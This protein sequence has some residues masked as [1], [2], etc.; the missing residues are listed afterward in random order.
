VKFGGEVRRQIN[1]NVQDNIGS[2]LYNFDNL[3]TSQNPYISGGGGTGIGFA[4][5][6]L[7]LGTSGSIIT[8]SPGRIETTIRACMST[9]R[10]GESEAY[11]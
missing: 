2:G 11:S 5:Y 9:T 3:F 7:G 4:S 6:M 10:A 1:N 8:A